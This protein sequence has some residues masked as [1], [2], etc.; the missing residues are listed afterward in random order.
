MVRPIP[1]RWAYDFAT[2]HRHGQR[3]V[4]FAKDL[5]HGNGH[6]TGIKKIP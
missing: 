2:R 5:M 3:L 4:A 1:I 6:A